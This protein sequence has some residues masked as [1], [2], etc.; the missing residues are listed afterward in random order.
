MA[1]NFPNSPATNDTFISPT[2]LQYIFDGSKWSSF[3]PTEA[4]VGT[5]NANSAI[6]LSAGGTDQSITLTPSGTGVVTTPASVGIGTT[7]PSTKVEIAA[8]TALAAVFSATISGT[9]MTVSTL[10]SGTIA[11]GQYLNSFNA[12]IR[13]TALGTG[14]G[15][16]GTYTLDSDATGAVVTGSYNPIPNTVRILNSNTTHSRGVPYGVIEFGGAVTSQGP[17]GFIQTLAGVST[18]SETWMLLGTGIGNN[19]TPPRTVAQLNTSTATFP[20]GLSLGEPNLSP[21]NLAISPATLFFNGRS[22]TSYA[23]DAQLSRMRFN[24]RWLDGGTNDTNAIYGEIGYKVDS[25]VTSLQLPSNFYIQT[26][27]ATGTL[28]ER[29]RIDKDGNVGIGTTTPAVKLQ[30]A[31]AVRLGNLF[32]LSWNDGTTY[33]TADTTAP[34]MTLAA[35]GTGAIYIGAGG[36]VGIGDLP[37]ARFDVK[38]ADGASVY[39]RTT[40]GTQ[41]GAQINLK[42]LYSAG[43]PVYGFYANYLTGIGNPAS[44]TLTVITQ[45]AEAIRVDSAGNVGIGA[46]TVPAQLTV[47]GA[48]QTVSALTDAGVKTGSIQIHSTTNTAG[49]GGALIF[50]ALS[51][52]VGGTTNQWA[53]KMLS[54]D[55]TGRGIGNLVISGRTTTSDNALTERVRITPT[56]FMGVGNNAPTR[57]LDVAGPSA[58]L[59]ITNT[60]AG[61]GGTMSIDAPSNN[62]AQIDVAGATYLR[63]NTN[64]TERT[65][66]DSTGN[67]YV[68]SGNF[69]QYTPNPTVLAAGANAI[70]AAGLQGQIFTVAAAVTT[71]VTFTLP[72]ATA[73]DTLFAQVPTT[74]IGFD[75]YIINAG[76]TSAAV[77]VAVNTGITLGA[78]SLTVAIGTSA[79]FRLRRT[80]ANTYLLY[81]MG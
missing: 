72:L 28:A 80:A 75:F 35:G 41:T 11:V 39:M 34:S 81:R 19:A 22:L 32:G 49:S 54:T 61:T 74:N 71:A 6:S 58:T 47:A 16:A 67:M 37:S 18:S 62:M 30:V 36:N 26:R 17:R 4:I 14:T 9:T 27:N 76:V 46:T 8:S 77:T 48:G 57:A 70:T 2:G 12:R 38:G 53:I 25:S 73:L 45:G 42:D 31:G 60:T 13:I 33:I 55:A 3:K 1:I 29:F 79:Q 50:S 64:G 44:N 24:T 78:G 21:L 69:W 59:G 63:I 51:A 65:R 56:G 5:F 66:I 68:E 52:A 43:I 7:T 10:T 40:G 23:A 15:G 20:G